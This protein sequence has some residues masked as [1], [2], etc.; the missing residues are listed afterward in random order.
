DQDFWG[1]DSFSYSIC[2]LSFPVQCDTAWVILNISPVND[3]PV[4]SDDT[5]I[6]IQDETVLIDVLLND[7]DVDVPLGDTLT[8]SILTGP[9]NGSATIENGS[10]LF[11][12]D[13][14]WCG[15]DSFQYLVCDTS[16]ACDTGW[17]FLTITC[18]EDPFY[19]QDDFIYVQAGLTIEIPIL[20]NDHPEADSSCISI[21]FEPSTGIATLNGSKL[22][23]ES[24][25][26]WDGIVCLTYS[27]CDLDGLRTAEA[28]VC[29]ETDVIGVNV[30]GGLSP[31]G[32]GINE[33]WLVAGLHEWPNHDISIFNRWGNE[34]YQSNAYQN[35]WDGTYKGEL[36]PAGTYFYIITLDP[37]DPST[38]V[39]NGSI[40]LRH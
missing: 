37:S 13:P 6:G 34:I 40:T 24:D 17:A 28:E 16:L 25:P 1:L 11:T 3:F 36:L 39:F 2:H 4:A 10:V 15:E 38:A 12:P 5:G 27:V 26:T 35:N 18:V 21:L 22:V 23:F 8:V 31:N 29:I 7:T 14:D 20:A 9:E 30:A 33:T 19:A 32:D